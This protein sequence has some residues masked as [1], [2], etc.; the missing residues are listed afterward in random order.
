MVTSIVVVVIGV[1]AVGIIVGLGWVQNARNRAASRK[2]L[3]RLDDYNTNESPSGF[4][5]QAIPEKLARNIRSEDP[6]SEIS[7]QAS[8][9]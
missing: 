6:D 8:N 1:I 2:S 9:S 7:D 5:S 3:A 4:P